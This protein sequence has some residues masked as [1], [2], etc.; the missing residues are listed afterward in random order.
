MVLNDP[1]IDL[2]LKKWSSLTITGET[3]V[4]DRFDFFQYYK[5]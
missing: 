1:P 5:A 3:T 4:L 2:N